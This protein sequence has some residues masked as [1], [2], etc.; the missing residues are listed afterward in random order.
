VRKDAEPL[1]VHHVTQTASLLVT[2]PA[3]EAVP[4][5]EAEG[6]RSPTDECDPLSVDLRDVAERRTEEASAEEVVLVEEIVEANELR[7]GTTAHDEPV[8]AFEAVPHAPIATTRS[9]SR[10]SSDL[11]PLVTGLL[12]GLCGSP[13]LLSGK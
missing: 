2:G 10:A 12:L 11:T 1:V 4:H 9:S 5:A 3:D 7:R 13:G 8:G 6:R